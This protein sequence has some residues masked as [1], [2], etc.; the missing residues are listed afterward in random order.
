MR[1]LHRK[2][3]YAIEISIQHYPDIGRHTA[4]VVI[5]DPSGARTKRIAAESAKFHPTAEAAQEQSK[6][7]GKSVLSHH[8]DGE[9]L[10]FDG[11]G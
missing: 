11:E 10:D 4:G 7:W 9:P 8:L 2:S 3:G 1:I 6:E 5:V